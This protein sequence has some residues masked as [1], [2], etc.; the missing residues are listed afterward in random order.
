[1]SLL[2]SIYFF[3]LI[4]MWLISASVWFIAG[5]YR[6]RSK[7]IYKWKRLNLCRLISEVTTMILGLTL[8][9]TTSAVYTQW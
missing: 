1:M 9:F 7:S 8:G 3:V 4:P 2:N 5:H 6:D